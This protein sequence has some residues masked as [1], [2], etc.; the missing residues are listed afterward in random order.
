VHDPIFFGKSRTQRW[1]AP[2]GDHGVLYLATEEYCAFMES[3]GRGALRTRLIPGSV[4]KL[5]ALSKI[6]LTK[7]LRLVDMVSSGGLTRLGA[8]GTIANGIGYRNSQRWSEALRSHPFKP[9]GI[10][11]RSRYDPA[12]TAAALFD[13]CASLVKVAETGKAWAEQ[14]ILLAEILDHYGFGT[15]L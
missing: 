1:D 2:K 4:L 12:R 15:D 8:D 9:H 11:Y 5:R 13:G 3:V 6:R 14:T 10:Y 7:D